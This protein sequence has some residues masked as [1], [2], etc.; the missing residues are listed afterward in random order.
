MECHCDGL[1]L[2]G[3][4]TSLPPSQ[5]Q[6]RVPYSLG[7]SLLCLSGTIMFPHAISRCF[8]A[9]EHHPPGSSQ[10]RW[11]AP[12]LSLHFIPSF[13]AETET[14]AAPSVKVKDQICSLLRNPQTQIQQSSCLLLPALCR[15]LSPP[16]TRT[17]EIKAIRNTAGF[18]LC[19]RGLGAGENIWNTSRKRPQ[20]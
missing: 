7:S 2:P 19:S 11:A 10:E 12:A 18:F 9:G 6:H 13:P 16:I 8:A 4:H 1:Q 3:K 15:P 20:Y 17:L 14:Q 5:I